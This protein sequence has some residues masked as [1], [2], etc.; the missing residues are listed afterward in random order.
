MMSGM[1]GRA[2]ILL[3]K[4]FKVPAIKNP[5]QIVFEAAPQ[6]KLIMT[7]L[8]LVIVKK[9]QAGFFLPMVSKST[10]DAKPVKMLKIY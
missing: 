4:V 9:N 6:F 8:R 1:I 7:K 3:E 5:V 10:P 2:V